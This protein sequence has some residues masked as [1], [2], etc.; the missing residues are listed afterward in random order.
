[1]AI[2]WGSYKAKGLYDELIRAAGKPRDA[3][4]PLCAYLRQL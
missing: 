1:M 3:A 4:A 2:R